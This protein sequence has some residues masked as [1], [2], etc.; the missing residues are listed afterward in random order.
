MHSCD[1]SGQR[2]S[3]GGSFAR[4]GLP[5]AVQSATYDAANRLTAWSGSTFSY[6]L[7]G[8][9]GSDGLTSYIWNARGQLA[10]LGGAKSAAFQYDGLGRRRNKTL[11]GT[12]SFLYDGANIVQELNGGTPTAN[13]LNGGEV[14]ETFLLQLANR[15]ARFDCLVGV[16]AG[17]VLGLAQRLFFLGAARAIH[18]PAL[19]E[20][21]ATDVVAA[22]GVGQQL[23][24]QVHVLRSL[25]EMMVRVDD[26]QAGLKDLFCQLA[27]PCGVGQRTV[28]G[29]RFARHCVL[30]EGR[31]TRTVAI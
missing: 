30:P 31:L 27:E 3:V 15:I 17:H 6:D 28:I 23:G 21:R 7:N 22:A 18:L 29:T 10:G 4:T 24:Q 8:N 14:D 11:N 26:R 12:T 20:D 16:G 25:P 5:Q 2:T 19:H 1:L 13:L 9:L